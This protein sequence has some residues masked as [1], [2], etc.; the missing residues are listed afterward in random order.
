WVRLLLAGRETIEN[1]DWVGFHRAGWLLQ[2]GQLGRLYTDPANAQQPFLNPPWFVWVC[3]PIGAWDSPWPPYLM[4]VG[5][6]VF[7]ALAA[8]LLVRRA[9]AASPERTLAAA[10]VL[11]GSAAWL[12]CVQT[13]QMSGLLLLL[14]AAA[15]QA[16]CA[17]SPFVA[18][19]LLSGL[20]IKP[21][22]FLPLAVLAAVGRHGRVVSGALTGLL[23][24]ALSTLPLG[25]GLWSDYRVASEHILRQA[26]DGTL[27]PWMPQP[28]LAFGVWALQPAPM[29]PAPIAWLL[30]AAPAAAATIACW[31]RVR[32][33]AALPRLVGVAV[34][35]LVVVDPYLFFYDGLLLAVPALVWF[36][37]AP[38]FASRRAWSLCGAL[39]GLVFV[40]QHVQ[41][42][43]H[44]EGC[45]PLIGPLCLLWLLVDARDILAA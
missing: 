23:L 1:K 9:T 37:Q 16:W 13:G 35:A 40:W 38:R 2:H 42:F 20:A 6:A 14:I 32:D 45:P 33:R 28:L 31:W 3:A 5:L 7:G 11:F 12:G 43:S 39:F 4:C 22:I 26:F 10:G 29:A 24:L 18:G 19:L 34:L 41:M 44:Y 21:N 17:G 15:L 8:L 30:P 25:L 36:L 27:A